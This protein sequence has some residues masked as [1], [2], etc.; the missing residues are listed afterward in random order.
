MFYSEQ[1]I[2]RLG[3]ETTEEFVEQ[4]VKEH[5][6]CCFQYTP[7]GVFLGSDFDSDGGIL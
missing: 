5:P 1:M 2:S 7:G 3:Y 4:Y 6:N